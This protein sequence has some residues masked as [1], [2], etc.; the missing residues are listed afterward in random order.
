MRPFTSLKDGEIFCLDPWI[1][2][3]YFRC[4]LACRLTFLNNHSGHSPYRANALFGE[5][6]RLLAIAAVVWGTTSSPL[7][8]LHCERDRISNTGALLITKKKLE[9]LIETVRDLFG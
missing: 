8:G 3:L 5:V 6:S 2:S 1:P 9:I 4:L 7:G